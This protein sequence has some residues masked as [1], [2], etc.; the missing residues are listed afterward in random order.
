MSLNEYGG[1][2][3]GESRSANTHT[4]GL[5]S[6]SAVIIL[7]VHNPA[8]I[9]G[10]I[11]FLFAAYFFLCTIFFTVQPLFFWPQLDLKLRVGV[12]P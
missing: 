5:I 11:L 9:F 7:A 6:L 12:R 3:P 10:D 2:S 4:C 8:M 1:W